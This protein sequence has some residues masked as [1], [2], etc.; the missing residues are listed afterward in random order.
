VYNKNA[1]EIKLWGNNFEA[2]AVPACIE[3]SSV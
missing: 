2:F 3:Y 1:Y